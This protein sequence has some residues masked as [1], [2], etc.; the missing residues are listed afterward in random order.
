MDG[1]VQRKAGD[2]ATTGTAAAG[3]TGSVGKST[4]VDAAGPGA[5]PAAQAGKTGAG[6]QEVEAAGG[7]PKVETPSAKGGPLSMA[8]SKQVLQD[9]FGA[10]KTISEGK[11]EVLDQAGFQA[12]WDK[13]YG[14]TQYAWAKWVAPGPGNLNGFAYAGVNY[15]NKTMA[16]ESTVPHEMLHSNAAADWSSSVGSPFDEGATD[17]MAQEAIKKAGYSA[18]VSYPDQISCIEAFLASGV[19]RAQLYT[20]YFKGGAAK[21]VGQHVDNACAGSW[22]DVKAAMEAKDWA[23]AKVKL[24]KKTK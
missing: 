24:A 19:T 23:K 18:P 3:S 2:G 14:T 4:L 8:K 21:I 1:A 6:G 17:M 10:Y 11:V 12:A 5:S 13:I 15:I 7:A 22:A 9:A 20:A 16:N